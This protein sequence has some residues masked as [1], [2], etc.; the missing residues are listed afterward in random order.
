ME[1]AEARIRSISENEIDWYVATGEP[2]MRAGAFGISHYGEVFVSD[3]R[4]SYSCFAG[5]PKRMLLAALTRSGFLLPL[6]ATVE[7]LFQDIRLSTFK[8]H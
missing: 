2:L 4:G 5:L 8:N 3:I 6:G 1:M 7:S